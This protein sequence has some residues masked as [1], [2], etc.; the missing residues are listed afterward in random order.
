[1]KRTDT[2]R[3]GINADP[4]ISELAD[5]DLVLV[6]GGEGN[7]ALLDD[8]EVLD[9]L[10]TADQGTTWTT[11]VCTGSLV[12]GAAGLLEGKRAT[13]HWAYR[14]RLREYGAEPTAERV[15]VD[16]KVVTAAGVSAGIDMA[17]E[18]AARDV[19][20]EYA[21]AIT[22]RARVRPAAAVRHRLA[23]EGS[24]RDRRSRACGRARRRRL[25]ELP[26]G[27]GQH[28]R[29]ASAATSRASGPKLA[30]RAPAQRAAAELGE[31]GGGAAP[32]ALDRLQR[33]GAAL[34]ARRRPG[35]E[36]G[37]AIGVVGL[38]ATNLVWL[39]VGADEDRG[40]QRQRRLGVRAPPRGRRRRPRCS[41]SSAGRSRS[42]RDRGRRRPPWPTSESMWSSLTALAEE[43]FAKARADSG[44]RPRGPAPERRQPPGRP[45]RWRRSDC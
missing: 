7:R 3:L 1:M 28:R 15:V 33:L 38:R 11:S 24:G 21:Q 17:F 9:W 5:P 25:G 2:D 8:E 29:P 14:D 37:G 19:G 39:L 20:E 6:P 26:E 12:L 32:E 18:L 35:G 45:G 13:S 36:R 34:L 40:R 31:L 16:G 23:R 27:P 42:A 4:A 10:R 41:R 44:S 30:P 22:A 43:A